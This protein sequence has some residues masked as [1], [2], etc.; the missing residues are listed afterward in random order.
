MP[1]RPFAVALAPFDRSILCLFLLL[2]LNRCTYI[3]EVRCKVQVDDLWSNE[4]PISLVTLVVDAN[5]GQRHWWI[6][7]HL[8]DVNKRHRGLGSIMLEA[9]VGEI[10]LCSV[11]LTSLPLWNSNSL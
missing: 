11:G 5:A 4:A 6:G 2:L 10:E 3:L 9:S 8:L 1:T 7:D